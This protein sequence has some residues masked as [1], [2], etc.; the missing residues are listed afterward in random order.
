[1]P[2]FIA[3]VA[4]SVR[5]APSVGSRTIASTLSLMKVSIWLI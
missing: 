4:T 3:L 2:A 1:M 5:A